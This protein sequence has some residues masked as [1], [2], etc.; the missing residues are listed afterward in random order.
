MANTTTQTPLS[1]KERRRLDAEMLRQRREE[2]GE[3][4]LTLAIAE[5]DTVRKQERRS[6]RNAKQRERKARKSQPAL[7]NPTPNHIYLLEQRIKDLRSKLGHLRAIN[8]PNPL[9]TSTTTKP[10]S[11]NSGIQ[12]S[13]DIGIHKLGDVHQE[14]FK[15]DRGTNESR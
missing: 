6:K 4:L 5:A 12:D 9:D 14:P 3:V 2:E 7:T 8:K 1:T 10:P 13:N 15:I 11:S